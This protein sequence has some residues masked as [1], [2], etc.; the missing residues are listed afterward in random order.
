MPDGGFGVIGSPDDEV[1]RNWH[2]ILIDEEG[3]YA[4][5]MGDKDGI[6][7]HNRRMLT[8]LAELKDDRERLLVIHSWQLH[9]H[10]CNTDRANAAEKRQAYAM[11]FAFLLSAGAFAFISLQLASSNDWLWIVAFIVG[12]FYVGICLWLVFRRVLSGRAL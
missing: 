6:P 12:A 2:R 1:L 11:T 4:K 9:D 10:S 8:Y 7:G 3:Q 5:F